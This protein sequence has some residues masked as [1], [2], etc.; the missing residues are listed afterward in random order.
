MCLVQA[1]VWLTTL[2][3]SL[4][5]SSWLWNRSVLTEVDVIKI[6]E[7]RPHHVINVSCLITSRLSLW[8]N[9]ECCR[10]G[11]VNIVVRLHCVSALS[12]WLTHLRRYDMVRITDFLFKFTFCPD[13]LFDTL[14]SDVL[15]I[16][17]FS[18]DLTTLYTNTIIYSRNI[19]NSVAF[20]YEKCRNIF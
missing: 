4:T 9:S 7:D 10:H 19:Y 20:V 1:W 8:T 16:S 17:V 13:L 15:Q 3:I 12:V 6:T 2:A 18:D 5:L 11:A 14:F